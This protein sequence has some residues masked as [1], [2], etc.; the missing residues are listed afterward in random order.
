MIKKVGKQERRTDAHTN[1]HA[2]ESAEA[3]VLQVLAKNNRNRLFEEFESNHLLKMDADE[4]SYLYFNANLQKIQPGRKKKLGFKRRKLYKRLDK[5]KK[6]RFCKVRAKTNINHQNSDLNLAATYGTFVAKP[7]QNTSSNELV[8]VYNPQQLTW[9]I[10]M[11]SDL[12]S[13]TCETK[14]R[15]FDVNHVENWSSDSHSGLNK[16]P[17]KFPSGKFKDRSEYDSGS[18]ERFCFSLL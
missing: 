18:I 2:G 14:N 5:Q 7:P 4:T 6:K 9:P 11:F 12:V 3:A 17:R 10:T 8:S 1:D 15:T 13:T 16:I